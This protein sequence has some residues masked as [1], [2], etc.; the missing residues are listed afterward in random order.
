MVD[1]FYVEGA[2]G[3]VSHVDARNFV[4]AQ[5]RFVVLAARHQLKR[6]LVLARHLNELLRLHLLICSKKML[7]VVLCLITLFRIVLYYFRGIYISC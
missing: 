1:G 3:H 6:R 4:A 7:T 5:R 2:A